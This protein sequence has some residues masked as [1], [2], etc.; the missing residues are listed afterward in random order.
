MR[1]FSVHF[2]PQAPL[3]QPP[4]S[5]FICLQ[6]AIEEAK[7]A[8]QQRDEVIQQVG[9]ELP[10]LSWCEEITNLI[11]LWASTIYILHLFVCFIVNAYFSCWGQKDLL[12]KHAEETKEEFW[13][14]IKVKVTGCSLL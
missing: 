1:G 2:S 6:W 9:A 12:L 5:A 13:S 8:L 7:S 11:L 4:L 3:T 14:T 10:L